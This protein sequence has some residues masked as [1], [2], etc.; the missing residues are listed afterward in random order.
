MSG[1]PHNVVQLKKVRQKRAEGKT[2]CDSGFHK[3]EVWK[4]RT[5]DVKLGKLVTT[6]RCKRCGEQRTK[7]A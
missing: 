7:L 1:P 3:W 4:Q 6:E 5:F 2:L